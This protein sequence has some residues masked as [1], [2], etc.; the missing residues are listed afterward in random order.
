MKKI[1]YLIVMLIL[2]QMQAAK[3]IVF[4]FN[5]NLLK[6]STDLSELIVTPKD[7]SPGNDNDNN[8]SN[9]YFLMLLLI[10]NLDKRVSEL[11]KAKVAK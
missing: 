5:E 8:A 10:E 2:L 7:V 3:A 9:C 4:D 1:K 11:E 6:E